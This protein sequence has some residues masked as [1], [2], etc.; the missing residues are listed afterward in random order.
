[1]A[2]QATGEPFTSEDE[3]FIPGKVYATRT[4][5]GGMDICPVLPQKA[6]ALVVIL[7]DT[8]ILN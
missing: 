1:M 5:R 8:G 4:K 6:L 7:G 3:N 2:G